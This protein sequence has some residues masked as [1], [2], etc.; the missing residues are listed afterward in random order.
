MKANTDRDDTA[1]EDNMDEE[2]T[3]SKRETA[4]QKPSRTVID[5]EAE[6]Q[7]APVNEHQSGLY[8]DEKD[9]WEMIDDEEAKKQQDEA[10]RKAL[11]AQD[12]AEARRKE[13]TFLESSF[14]EFARRIKQQGL[15][16][17]SWSTPSRKIDWRQRPWGLVSRWMRQRHTY[18]WPRAFNSICM[19][20][21]VTK[22][23]SPPY[24]L[25]RRAY[26]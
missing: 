5:L 25:A 10:D 21:R 4:K 23:P 6:D 14:Q 7:E 11:E 8:E 12:V 19:L 13:L 16:T 26:P 17:L 9:D 22:C 18:P 15:Q 20:I 24:C 1:K 3:G 2:N